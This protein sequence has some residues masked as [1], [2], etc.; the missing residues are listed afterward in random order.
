MKKLL[1]SLIILFGINSFNAQITVNSTHV[2]DAGVDVIQAHDT[3]PTGVTIGSSG[4]NQTWDFSTVLDDN[5]QDTLKFRNAVGYP[6]ATDFPLANLVLIDTQEDSSWIYLTKN[7]LGL[8][9][10]G[11]AQ[12]QD[13]N[14]SSTQFST[15][16]LTFPST[17]GTSFGG[18]P[19]VAS[20]GQFPLGFDPDGP[21]PSGVIDSARIIRSTTVTSNIDAWGNVITPFGT[22]A[23]LRQIVS[24]ETIDST[25]VLEGGTW[26]LVS[27]TLAALLNTSPVEYD[28]TRTARWWTDDANSKLPLVEMDYESN[29]TVNNVDWQ[30]SSPTLN[31]TEMAT[32]VKVELYP[33]PTKNNVLISTSYLGNK[34]VSVVDATGKLMFEQAYREN[35]IDIS[36]QHYSNGIYFYTIQDLKGN[37]LHSS[38]FIV[39][40]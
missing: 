3:I 35:T 12:T 39:A 15:V 32:D 2:V 21:G 37:V 5:G 40:R 25:F 9:V 20:L 33:N 10:L 4:A 28:T 24:E 38:K 27:P 17:M 13:G 23:S 26:S 36:T 11:I 29:G 8:A 1:L 18:T 16:I 7:A 30:K 22:F 31:V 19:V 14:T 34:V 6:K